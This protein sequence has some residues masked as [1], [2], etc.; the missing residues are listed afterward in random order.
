[1]KAKTS[2]PK[3][4]AVEL[5]YFKD[6]ILKKREDSLKEIKRLENITMSDET[7]QN[8]PVLDSTY[9]YHMADVGTDSQER[10]KAFL[11]LSRENKYLSYLNSALERVKNG[12]FGICIECGQQI[13]KER[14]EEVPHTQHCVA[15]KTKVKK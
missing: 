10:E 5:D 12:E 11:W 9:A 6:L 1:M 4:N 8:N 14:L 2:K 7:M 3:W 15:C 13:P